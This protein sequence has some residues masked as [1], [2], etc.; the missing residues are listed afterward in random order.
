MDKMALLTASKVEPGTAISLR[1]E[2]IRLLV[3]TLDVILR[4]Q[5]IVSSATVFICLW[6]CY[7][8]SLALAALLLASKFA[9]FN[10][11]AVAKFGALYGYKMSSRTILDLWESRAVKAIREKVWFEFAVFILGTGNIMFVLLFWPGWW[12]LAGACWTVWKL[13][14]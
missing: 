5:T 8:G 6:A 4:F 1:S 11:I 10:A 2:I 3:P 12:V 9:A 13:W 14:G 7:L